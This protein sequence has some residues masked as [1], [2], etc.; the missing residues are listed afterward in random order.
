MYI[1]ILAAIRPLALIVAVGTAFLSIHTASAV[2]LKWAAQNDILT[3]D[4]HAQNHATTNNMVSHAYEPLVRFDKNYKV[5]PALATSWQST[6]P[7]TV[8]FNLRKNVK[9][10]D[11]TPF[12]ADDVLFSFDRIRQPQGTMQI[13]VG[14]VKEIKKIDDYTVDV[15]SDKP[16]PTLLNNFTTFLIMSK[17]WC[18]KNKSE[19]IQDYKA[20]EITHASTNTNGTGPYIIKE[21]QPDQKLVMTA[22]KGWWDKLQGNV[23]DVVYTPI[24]SDPTRVAALLAGNVDAVTDLPTQDVARLRNTP[25]LAVLDGPEVRTI[26][27]ALDQGSEELKYGPKGKNIFKD[28]RVR[29]ALSVSIDRVAIQ[30]SIMRGLSLPAS[31]MV[32]PGVNGYSADLDKVQPADIDSAKKLLADAGY[33]NGVEF[34]LD[35]PNNRYVNDEEVCQAIINMWAKAGIKA[36]LNA[37]NFGPFIAKV[38]NFDS[39]AYMLGWGVAN[40]DAQYS[41]QSLVMTRTQGADGSFN[42]SKTNNAKLDALVEA[43]KGETDKNKR[44]AIIKEALT[45]TR[46]EVLYIP[47]HHQMRPWA[48]KQNIT[49]SHNSNDAPKMYYVNVK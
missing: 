3:L 44:D 15:I 19:K 41:L 9:F 23:T 26:F 11:G 35:C 18:V 45:L 36:K 13:Y 28:V 16:N 34:T 48:M 33:P 49:M 32:A 37:M 43:M 20:K 40:Y 31:I 47:L 6:S 24:K 46:D 29:K 14:G 1:R 22:N 30:R 8:R 5:E 27:L 42:F 21:W 12:T 17:V 39:S 38:Q 2:E 25:S 4:P 10:H 7:T